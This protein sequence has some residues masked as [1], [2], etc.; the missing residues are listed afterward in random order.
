MDST[1]QEGFQGVNLAI[2]YHATQGI[3]NIEFIKHY[4]KKDCNYLSKYH[5]N[6]LYF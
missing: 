4:E 3:G 6:T 5:I 1:I 2:R